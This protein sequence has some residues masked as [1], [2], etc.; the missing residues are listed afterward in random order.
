MDDSPGTTGHSPDVV[1]RLSKWLFADQTDGF[2]K[3]DPDN[4]VDTTHEREKSA[5]N[6]KD[7]SEIL[8]IQRSRAKS[9]GTFITRKFDNNVFHCNDIMKPSVSE[10]KKSSLIPDRRYEEVLSFWFDG[11]LKFNYRTKW[12]PD[13]STSTQQNADEVIGMQ[14]AGLFRNALSG[15]LDHWKGE[16]I[17]AH[18]ALI[19]VLDQFSRHIF[20]LNKVPNDH[21]DRKLA[22][23]TALVV[24]DELTAI[25]GWDQSLSVAQFVFALMPYRHSPTI[26]RLKNVL[27]KLNERESQEE[28]LMDLMLKFRKQTMRR[29]Q[30]L[31]DV[32]IVSM[33]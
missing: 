22:D 15:S 21:N 11:D 29:L 19:I 1:T 25:P 31:Q 16:G 32:D 4:H 9:D 13:G 14:F 26:N 6:T 18:V 2:L 10:M 27:D 33:I 8:M 30:H 5:F 20:R 17:R 7:N 23:S 3:P 24:A 12:F 28:N